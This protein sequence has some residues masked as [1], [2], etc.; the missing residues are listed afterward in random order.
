MPFSHADFSEEP[1]PVNL[2]EMA[3]LLLSPTSPQH[4]CALEASRTEF[5]SPYLEQ[6]LLNHKLQPH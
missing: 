6:A 3:G 5:Q 2:D 1:K 4:C